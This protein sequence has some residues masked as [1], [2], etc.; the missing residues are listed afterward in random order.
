MLK[1]IDNQVYYIEKIF[2]NLYSF[3]AY[4]NKKQSPNQTNQH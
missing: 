4:L 3:K 1:F 2:A